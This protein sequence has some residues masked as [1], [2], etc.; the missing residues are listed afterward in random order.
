MIGSITLPSHHVKNRGL[1]ETKSTSVIDVP[2]PKHF[3]SVLIFPSD[4]LIGHDPLILVST[5]SMLGL[6]GSESHDEVINKLKRDLE[7][8]SICIIVPFIEDDEVFFGALD[9][10]RIENDLTEMK[11]S[12]LSIFVEGNIPLIVRSV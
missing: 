4:G 10:V 7:K 8:A 6:K 2:R 1:A 11:I 12:Y 3:C 9:V 5:G